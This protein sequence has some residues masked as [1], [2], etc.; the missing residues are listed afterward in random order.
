MSLVAQE[1]QIKNIVRKL[2]SPFSFEM[3]LL[4]SQWKRPFHNTAKDEGWMFLPICRIR[5]FNACSSFKSNFHILS[6][7]LSIRFI[8]S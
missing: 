7:I 6:C 4:A 2:H 5:Q 8:I 1:K 3:Y